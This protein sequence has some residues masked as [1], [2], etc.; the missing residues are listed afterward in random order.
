M[1]AQ[2]GDDQYTANNVSRALTPPA[3]IV[4]T[5]I[6]KVLNPFV[7]FQNHSK[8][9]KLFLEW[10][11]HNRG[12]LPTWLETDPFDKEVGNT[13]DETVLFVDLGSTRGHQSI[14]LRERFPTMSGRIVIQDQEHVISTVKP[15]H[16][17]ET[18]VYGFDTPQTVEGAKAYYVRMILHDYLDEQYRK[19]LRNTIAAMTEDSVLL[20][21][22]VVLPE[23]GAAW[24]ATL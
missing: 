12:G 20:I 4:I 2:V 21:D 3:G 8:K 14:E 13:T 11:A 9:F 17:I 6:M 24:R 1:V 22:E 18:M 10:M 7:W 16:G 19:I 5:Y 23:F 15:P